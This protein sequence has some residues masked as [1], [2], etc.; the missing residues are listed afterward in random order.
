[1]PFNV[2]KNKSKVRKDDEL[3][4]TLKFTTNDALRAASSVAAAVASISDMASFPPTRAAA[5][6]VL[7]IL[8]TIQQIDSNRTSCYKLARRAA[9]ILVELKARMEGRWESAPKALVD[10]VA[11]FE[12]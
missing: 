10:S 12:A 1:M 4:P 9:R 2:L 3:V 8:E 5:S 6:L 11:S 7:V